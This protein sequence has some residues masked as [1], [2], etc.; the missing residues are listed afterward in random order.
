MCPRTQRDRVNLII[1]TK[2]IILQISV[3][4]LAEHLIYAHGGIDCGIYMVA[5]NANDGAYAEDIR[6]MWQIEKQKQ[7]KK[8]K[9]IIKRKSIKTQRK[10]RIV[11]LLIG[12]INA[13]S[14]RALLFIT[15]FPYF[16]FT[17][18]TSHEH[19]RC[20]WAEIVGMKLECMECRCRTTCSFTYHFLFLLFYSLAHCRLARTHTHPYRTFC[21]CDKSKSLQLLLLYAVIRR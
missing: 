9:K 21:N 10:C 14:V 13:Y 3:V 20:V 2:I 8:R 12:D 19:D 7:R 1:L 15:I 18:L 4:K 11:W 6:E 16:T 5:T 17:H